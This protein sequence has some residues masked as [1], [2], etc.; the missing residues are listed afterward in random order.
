MPP[1]P[2]KSLQPKPRLLAIDDDANICELLKVLTSGAFDIE[3]TTDSNQAGELLANKT[4]DLILTDMQM[5]GQ[6]G[7][8]LV[9]TAQQIQPGTPILVM[10]G[11]NSSEEF[12]RRALVQGASGYV[13][14]PF[15][16]KH[17]LVAQLRA[18]VGMEKIPS[19]EIWTPEFQ[20]L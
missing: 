9:R 15:P 10:S 2:H 13:A 18:Y 7:F 12:V 16:S 19:S 6:T 17:D 5:P 1:A 3:V 20:E 14:K 4:Y 11:N 8:D